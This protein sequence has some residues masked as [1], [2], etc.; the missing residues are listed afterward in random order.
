M[1]EYSVTGRAVFEAALSLM[2]ETPTSIY[3]PDLEEYELRAVGIINILM[4][5]L[6][7]LS[8]GFGNSTDGKRP[9]PQRLEVLDDVIQMDDGVCTGV[10][11]YGLAAHLQFGEDNVRVS[12]NSQ[13][14]EELRD[15]LARGMPQEFESI[16][17]VYGGWEYNDYGA[18]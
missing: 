16:E 6:F 7:P 18:W 11:P 12:Y 2:N 1:S 8:V 3:A 9:L 17:D 13:R 5:E 14:Y 15:K 4:V 10:L